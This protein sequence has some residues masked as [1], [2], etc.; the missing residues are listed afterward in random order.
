MQYYDANGVTVEY[1]KDIDW[2]IVY[3][4]SSNFE[5]ILWELAGRTQASLILQIV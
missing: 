3:D 5:N 4:E 2:S 1:L